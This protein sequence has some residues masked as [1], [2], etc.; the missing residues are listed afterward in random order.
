MKE[1]LR[2][3]IFT[4]LGHFTNDGN[5]LL[6]PTLIAYYK[7]IPGVS[8]PLLGAMAIVYNLI[9]GFLGSPIG[10]LADR[11]D[12]DGFLIFTGIFIEATSVMLFGV[13]F[14][15]SHNII[16]YTIL[17]AAV[18]LGIGQAFYHP[19]GASILSFTYGKKRSPTA[20]GY[21]GS[22]GSI[23]RAVIP[24][25]LVY[26]IDFFGKVNG[27][28]IIGVYTFASAFIILAG[29]SFF[30]RSKYKIDEGK[31]TKI[32]R[33]KPKLGDYKK[34]LIALTL[35]VFIRSIFMMG[36]VTFVPDYLDDVLNSKILM[37][38]VVSISFL[39]AVAGQPYFGSMVRKR[40]GRFTVALTTIL[41]TI[42]FGI[43]L[44][45][46]TFALLTVVYLLYVFA[47]FSGF[48]VLLGYVAQV[49]PSEFST[50]SN[51]LIWSFGNI[52]GG[53]VGIAIVTLL[54][55]LKVTLFTS[56]IYMLIFAIIS[57]I[58]LPLLPKNK[59][60]SDK[61]KNAS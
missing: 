43:F 35:I 8:V 58:L 4:S 32:T 23:G 27:L 55:F 1:D 24:F 56:F 39:S 26:S 37:G 45:V 12:H 20:M 46:H 10:R 54:L 44:I 57:V 3:L 59:K 47:A 22:F 21:N 11:I 17:I 42:F 34:F 53:S 36:T 41:S 38:D 40:G 25:I 51:A 33:E 61:L 48:P 50:E 52:V 16:D 29:L 19:I 7:L 15:V 60:E 2:S 30:R 18:L 5:F 31:V 49:I 13:S 28:Y 9:S 6:F 14:I